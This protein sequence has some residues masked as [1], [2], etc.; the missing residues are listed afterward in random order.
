MTDT[1][2]LDAKIK[3]SGMKLGKIAEELDLT[4]VTFQ[5]KRNNEAI[6]NAVEI[7]KLC[8]LLKINKVSERMAIFFS[9]M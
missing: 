9:L 6:F 7:D 5:R 3:D 4:Y 2:A 8:K 1:D